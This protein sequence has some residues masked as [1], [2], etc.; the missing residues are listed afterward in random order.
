MWLMSWRVEAQVFVELNHG[1]V[2]MYTGCTTSSNTGCSLENCMALSSSLHYRSFQDVR[3]TFPDSTYKGMVE[4]TY[5]PTAVG[6]VYFTSWQRAKGT[7]FDIQ[8]GVSGCYPQDSTWRVIGRSS[9]VTE[10]FRA[11]VSTVSLCTSSADYNVTQAFSGYGRE[12]RK[13]LMYTIKPACVNCFVTNAADSSR[14]FK[15]AQ[16]QPGSYEVTASISYA[17]GMVSRTLT[18]NVEAIPPISRLS[19]SYCSDIAD[20]N[21]QEHFT[22]AAGT[23]A[24]DCGPTP[25]PTGAIYTTGGNTYFNPDYTGAPASY[26]VTLRATVTTAAGCTASTAKSIRIGQSFTAFAGADSAVCTGGASVSLRGTNSL[27]L[28]GTWQGTGVVNNQFNPTTVT[29]GRTYEIT[30]SVNNNG[31]LRQDTRSIRVLAVPALTT[32]KSIYTVSCPWG[33]VDLNT[34]FG[35]RDA[36]TLL[37][38]GVEWSCTDAAVNRN[39]VDGHRLNLEGLPAGS[40][41]LKFRYTND[42]ACVAEHSLVNGLDVRPTPFA[43]PQIVDTINCKPGTTST[44]AIINPESGAKY[45]WYDDPVS[46]LPRGQGAAFTTPVLMAQDTFYVAVT[47][48]SCTTP[49][50]PVVVTVIDVGEVYAGPD[51]AYCRNAVQVQLDDPLYQVKPP[52]GVFSGSGVQGTTFKGNALN[53]GQTYEVTYT[54][55]QQGCAVYDTRLISL[56]IVKPTLNLSPDD[57]VYVGQLVQLAHPYSN[58]IESLWELGDGWTRRGTTIQHYYYTPGLLTLKLTVTLRQS[59]ETCVSTF[60][61][62]AGVTVL[63]TT[64]VVT[65]LSPASE[66]TRVYPLPFV[67]QLMVETADTGLARIVLTNMQGQTIHEATLMLSTMPT[68]VLSDLHQ[69]LPSGS[70]VL[71]VYTARQSYRFKILKR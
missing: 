68:A 40:R 1:P 45:Q 54:V 70:Y 50:R 65:A 5:R 35:P 26:L 63:D 31:C 55:N 71:T 64:D 39:I 33:W 24:F 51:V 22:V 2:K 57:T 42:G 29:A 14:L 16:A 6:I 8:N 12:T 48:G 30:Y 62:P 27:G 32:Q 38:R 58:A 56:G 41:S 23:L 11:S 44:L 3:G 34:A 52:G 36:G 69:G 47:K 21:L 66:A 59:D 46:S 67:H 20:I 61:Y 49:R 15:P 43:V 13:R 28:P 53:L 19:D 18:I 4:V 9:L 10:D 37:T 25:C 60:D 17:N 7:V